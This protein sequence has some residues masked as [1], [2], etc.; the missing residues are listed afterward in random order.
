MSE[1]LN[2]SAHNQSLAEIIYDY[3]PRLSRGATDQLHNN[4]SPEARSDLSSESESDTDT[5]AEDNMCHEPLMDN[6]VSQENAVNPPLAHELVPPIQSLHTPP[7]P[8]DYFDEIT[9]LGKIEARTELAHN[10]CPIPFDYFKGL[11]HAKLEQLAIFPNDI[12]SQDIAF[13]YHL[14][15]DD[16]AVNLENIGYVQS[17]ICNGQP[18]KIPKNTIHSGIIACCTTYLVLVGAPNKQ[19][20]PGRLFII[21]SKRNSFT[22]TKPMIPQRKIEP[23]DPFTH[24]DIMYRQGTHDINRLLSTFDCFKS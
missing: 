14:T 7:S 23:S 12:L 22:D 21:Y 11:S 9:S 18:L 19:G 15:A 16:L 24:L 2:C 10:A 20:Y 6:P 13:E 3:A 4:L 8:L 5:Q 1:K 17:F